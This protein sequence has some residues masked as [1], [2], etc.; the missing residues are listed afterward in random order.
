MFY[1][2]PETITRLEAAL[3]L[4][5]YSQEIVQLDW[6]NVTETV[7]DGCA[8]YPSTT[9]EVTDVGRDQSTETL[10]VLIPTGVTIDPLDRVRARGTVYEVHGYAFDFH[11]PFTGWEPGGQL[12]I[13]RRRG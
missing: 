3:V 13:T 6:T 5:P 11:N 1:A 8:I 9:A 2:Y 4:D 7:I 10:T 12:I